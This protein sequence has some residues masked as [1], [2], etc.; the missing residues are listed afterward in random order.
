MELDAVVEEFRAETAPF[1]AGIEAAIE[2]ARAFRDEIHADIAALA[3]LQ[4]ALDALPRE[5]TVWVNLDTSGAGAGAFD[6]AAI[7]AQAD[8]MKAAREAA[9]GDAAAQEAAAGAMEHAGGAASFETLALRELRDISASLD[10]VTATLGEA[11]QNL[12]VIQRDTADSSA[13]L[14]MQTALMREAQ[15]AAGQSIVRV[16]NSVRNYNRTLVSSADAARQARGIWG[17]LRRDVSLFGGALGALPLVGVAGGFHV[18][19][20]AVAET[21]AV[22][23]PAGVA[24]A[25][26]G[27]AAA[28]TLQDIYTRMKAV[29]TTST[30]FGQNIY[31]MTGGLQA[32]AQAVQPEVYQLFGQAL[33]VMNSKTGEFTTIARQAGAVLDQLGA[34][35]SVALT[36]GGFGQ[37]LAH[38]PAD[39]AQIGDIIG[40]IFG[41]IGNALRVMPGYAE[42]LLHALDDVTKGIESIT[43]SGFGQWVLGAGMAL[44]GAVL[45]LGLGATAAVTMGNALVGLAAKF[46]LAS[47]GALAFDAAQFGAGIKQMLAGVQLLGGELLAMSSAEDVATAASLSLEGVM[48]ALAAVNPLVWVGGAITGLALL[49]DHVIHASNATSDYVTSAQQALGTVPVSQLAVAL[50]L[51][52]AR[53]TAALRDAQA[54]LNDSTGRLSESQFASALITGTLSARQRELWK[55]YLDT[56]GLAQ[57]LTTDQKNYST[58]LAAAGGNLGL[59]SAAGITSNQIMSASGE[60]LKELVLEARAAAAAQQALALGTGRSAAALNAQSSEF[61]TETVPALQKVTQAEDALLNVVTG[62]E[63]SFVSFQQ[64][65]QGTSA[66]FTQPSG[67]GPSAKLAGASLS[68]LNEQSLYLANTFYGIAI[69]ALQKLADSLQQQHISTG[70][71]AKVVATGASEMLRYTRGN[72]EANATIVALINN[73]LGPGTVSLQN[74]NTWVKN[75]STSLQGM[76]AIIAE[77]TIKAGTLANV[78]E[79]QLNAQFRQDLLQTSGADAALKAYTN[80]LTHNQA[81]TA[82]GHALRQAFITDMVNAGF[83]VQ[84]ATSYVNGL[85]AAINSV[86]TSKTVTIT[87]IERSIGATVPGTGQPGVTAPHHARGWKVPGYGGGDVVPAWLEPGEAVVPKHLVPAVAPF[88]GAHHVPGFA[89]GGIVHGGG[90]DMSDVTRIWAAELWRMDREKFGKHSPIALTEMQAILRGEIPGRGFL[91]RTALGR[92]LGSDEHRDT[93]SYSGHDIAYWKTLGER[94]RLSENE[95]KAIERLQHEIAKAR[96]NDSLKEAVRLK[97]EH[98][99]LEDEWWRLTDRIRAYEKAGDTKAADALIVARAAVN[100]RENKLQSRIRTIDRNYALVHGDAIRH[101]REQDAR[102]FRAYTEQA[103]M[104]LVEMGYRPV[105]PGPLLP[106]ASYD[107][108]GYLPVGLS[109]AFNGTGKPEPVGQAA[110]GDVH[111]HLHGDLADDAIW[112]RLQVRTL[113]YGYANSGR[114]TGVWQPGG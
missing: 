29:Q 22:V 4:A 42:T 5:R 9:Y 72:T 76:N 44:H 55:N 18:L 80:A 91:P 102:K 8:A 41:T 50:T 75:N 109:M 19:A 111:L 60:Q 81:T 84:R 108:G 83:S 34:R 37:F 90:W 48:S 85:S 38:G 10:L 49:A 93:A 74:L 62:G 87:T 14:M 88:L 25:A 106:S 56:A 45:W 21:I 78:L 30:A 103:D 35:A 39:L 6:A 31:P 107:R 70:D 67:L 51:E 68:G 104:L 40:N 92:L 15:D 33:V 2:A 7:A 112:E 114:P 113:D 95:K 101:L 82:S 66:K 27:A 77:S 16:D 65:I 53:N 20:D 57:Q 52:Q 28:P 79:T 99:R 61:M 86:P 94:H 63:Q 97:A 12:A 3:E 59:L 71:L 23:V 32:M 54:A 98:T 24:F 96:L 47:E 1:V 17:F 64:A 105:L 100:A 58:V 13:D 26:F 110:G 36:S 73:A 11:Q 46:G 89:P 43:G 69:P